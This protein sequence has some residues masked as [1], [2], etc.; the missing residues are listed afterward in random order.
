MSRTTGKN[1][2]PRDFYPT[3]LWG[4]RALA[5]HAAFKDIEYVVDLG[6]G[7]GRIGYHVCD[8]NPGAK[9]WMIDINLRHL[10]RKKR[11][12]ERRIKGDFLSSKCLLPPHGKNVLFVSNPPFSLKFEFVQRAV[13]LVDDLY[14]KKSYAIFLLSFHFIGTLERALWLDRNKYEKF[15]GMAPR[16]TFVHGHSDA[17]EYGWFFWHSGKKKADHFFIEVDPEKIES[18]HGKFMDTFFRK[19][20]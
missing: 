20:N 15:V 1:K 19:W 6:C 5:K 18:A 11:R 14:S 8:V 3:P 10:P 16:L 4:V 17:T 2:E 12:G 9:P 13:Q 7:D